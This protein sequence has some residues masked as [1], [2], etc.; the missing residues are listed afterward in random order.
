AKGSLACPVVVPSGG[1]T[2]VPRD[3]DDAVGVQFA[4]NSV[5]GADAMGC[6]GWVAEGGACAAAPCTESI[7]PKA[8]RSACFVIPRERASRSL[9]PRL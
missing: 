7:I 3:G 6:D 5:G 9:V 2:T 8:K 4:A 1:T